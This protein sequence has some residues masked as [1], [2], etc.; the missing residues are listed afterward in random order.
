MY[1]MSKKFDKVHSKWNYIGLYI[2]DS[3]NK[4]ISDSIANVMAVDGKSEKKLYYFHQSPTECA[5]AEPEKLEFRR[6]NVIRTQKAW[7]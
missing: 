2:C 3:C 4:P 5:N 7:R 6:S 1:K